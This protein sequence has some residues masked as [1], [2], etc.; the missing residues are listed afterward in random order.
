MKSLFFFALLFASTQAHAAVAGSSRFHFRYE[1]VEGE[2]ATLCTHKQIRDLPDWSVE[3]KT[4]YGT[5]T[6][7]VHLI[8]REYPRQGE[9]GVEILY[10]VT[11]P[12]DT[13]TSPRKYHSTSALFRLKG[14]S[15]LSSF[16]LSQGVENDMAS[17]VLGWSDEAEGAEAE[18]K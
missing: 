12:G 9:T 1:P 14:D 11:E 13:P 7:T 8:V 16:L 4:G 3:C 6:F 5:K 17:L 10:W 15:G 2:P 18:K